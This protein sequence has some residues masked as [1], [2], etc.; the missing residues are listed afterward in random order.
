MLGIATVP[1][2]Y[3]F[4]RLA[5]GPLAGAMAAWLMAVSHLHIHYSRMGQIFGFSDL[6]MVL[7]LVLLALVYERRR[8]CVGSANDGATAHA[9]G[10]ADGPSPPSPARY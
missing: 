3:V 9:V 1:L 10:S 8:T 7:L 4:G 6:L 2:V 5:W